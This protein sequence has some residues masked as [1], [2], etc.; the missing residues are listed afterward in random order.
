M[1]HVYLNTEAFII[2][3]IN[4]FLIITSIYIIVVVIIKMQCSTG[5]QSFFMSNDLGILPFCVH[6]YLCCPRKPFHPQKV[7]P[8]QALL[9]AQ[10][11]PFEQW[12]EE[13][14][15]WQLPATCCN[16]VLN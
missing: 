14:Y 16:L 15:V 6:C 12:L 5:S 11:S 1:L 13:P 8:L 2:I 10:L 3:I 9:Q 4:Y 7:V